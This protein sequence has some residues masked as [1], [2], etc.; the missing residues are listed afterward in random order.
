[1][2]IMQVISR[3]ELK[4]I[5]AELIHGA[6]A[7][8]Q[9]ANQLSTELAWFNEVDIEKLW[10]H[11]NDL[12]TFHQDWSIFPHGGHVCFKH[13][14]T[15]QEVEASVWFGTEFGILDPQFF[16][17]FLRT[18]PQLECPREILD[19]FHDMA[20]AMDY[21]ESEGHLQRIEGAFNLTGVFAPFAVDS[22]PDR[23]KG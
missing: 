3:P 15:N 1:V 22:V 17:T 19:T 20:K 4:A 14:R 6:R 12:K 7:F 18:S 9:T 13:T 16:T 21:L 23:S 2:T 11:G 5:E 8:R 10:E